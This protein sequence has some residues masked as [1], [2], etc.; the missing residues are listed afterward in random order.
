MQIDIDEKQAG[1]I[2]EL[3]MANGMQTAA[4]G[5]AIDLFTKCQTV[6]DAAEAERRAQEEDPGP[7]KPLT[8]V[9]G[10]ADAL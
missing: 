1:M 9:P 8:E 6:R 3:L 5:S 7:V 2:Q 10:A 4:I